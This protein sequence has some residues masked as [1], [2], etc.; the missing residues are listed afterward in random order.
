[1]KENIEFLKALKQFDKRIFGKDCFVSVGERSI[2]FSC[3]IRVEMY[4]ISEKNF[5]IAVEQRLID[6]GVRN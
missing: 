1:V 4:D 5:I 3:G 2:E 6:F